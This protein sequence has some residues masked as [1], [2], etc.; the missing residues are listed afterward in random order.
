[1][2][3]GAG[4]PGRVLR[5]GGVGDRGVLW[6]VARYALPLLLALCLC[7]S[8]VPLDA[9][10]QGP[11][12]AAVIVDYGDGRVETFCVTFAEA[13]IT[14]LEL[15]SRA[16]IEPVLGTSSIGMSVCQIGDTGCGPGQNCF[17]QCQGVDCRYWAYFRWQDGA[18]TYSPTGGG[19]RQVAN[20][21][22]DAWMWSDGKS[23][24][25]LSPVG[26]CGGG[27]SAAAP[28]DTP[29]AQATE[30]PIDTPVPEATNTP[31]VATAATEA[32]ATAVP[33]ASEAEGATKP[34]EGEPAATTVSTA[35]PSAAAVE[36]ASP[37]PPTATAAPVAES[38]SC[39]GGILGWLALAAMVGGGAVA[40]VR[41][42]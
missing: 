28:T 29:L 11:N 12:E 34:A 20:G 38:S 22:A 5:R 17:C 35:A 26:I 15:L 1:V 10:A 42:K 14:G 9:S 3:L 39:L 27:A 16:G 33:T 41:R 30:A 31:A 24:P 13:S 32:A 2:I 19:Q 4:K 6:G 40:V 25:A 23:L 18:W 8:V 36:S 21:D 7:T 37:V